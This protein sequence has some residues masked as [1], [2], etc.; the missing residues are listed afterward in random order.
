[1]ARNILVT[2][3]S[4]FVMGNFLEHLVDQEQQYK[5]TVFYVPARSETSVKSIE[6]R[7]FLKKQV[8]IIKDCDLSRPELALDKEIEGN[9]QEKV[10]LIIHGAASTTFDNSPQATKKTW[11]DNVV[12]TQNLIEFAKKCKR[13]EKFLYLGTVF[14][15]GKSS[16]VMPEGPL[17]L[18]ESD[19]PKVL[20]NL[21][22]FNNPYEWSKWHAERIFRN[23]IKKGL[24]GVIARFGILVG[25]SRDHTCYDGRMLYQYLALCGAVLRRQL[26][27]KG[28]DMKANIINGDPL[29]LTQHLG[30][31]GLRM[32][33][34]E[35]TRKNF[36]YLDNVIKFLQ[37]VVEQGK[38]GETYQRI[39]PNWVLGKQVGISLGE[40]L[41]IR[42]IR[43]VGRT[44]ENPNPIEQDIIAY[45]EDFIPYTINDDPECEMAKTNELLKGLY[46]PGMTDNAFSSLLRTYAVREIAKVK[47][48]S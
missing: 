7:G 33:G 32:V 34:R 41:N 14:E 27:E 15:R 22:Q 38:I 37:R 45:N 24:P 43:Y 16:L 17:P 40:A 36:E 4:G 19:D 10:D 3:A 12:G 11:E 1:M 46:L 18:M 48:L 47:S 26:R 30:E 31:E 25:K 42:G 39:N 2:G 23:E 20:P 44:V 35:D 5:D 9:L 28:I 8:R 6:S 29:D 13:L 21:D